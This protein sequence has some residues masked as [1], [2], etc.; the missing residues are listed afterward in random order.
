MMHFLT[1]FHLDRPAVLKKL[2]CYWSPQ[3]G[4]VAALSAPWTPLSLRR[5]QDISLVSILGEDL[6]QVLIQTVFV[7]SSKS[8][9]PAFVYA[10]ICMSVAMVLIKTLARALSIY[11]RK[12]L[13]SHQI[14]LRLPDA[15]IALVTA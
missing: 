11:N 3:V 10:S 12:Q 2:I 5:L 6:P 9:T 4:K 8:S 14:A 15:A 13:I 1:F 7:V